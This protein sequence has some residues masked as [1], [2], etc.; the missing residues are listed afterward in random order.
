MKLKYLTW[1]SPQEVDRGEIGH[2]EGRYA[3]VGDDKMGAGG[4][5]W[6]P[7]LMETA[8]NNITISCFALCSRLLIS[9]IKNEKIAKYGKN[10]L[11]LKS[12]TY[13]L[14]MYRLIFKHLS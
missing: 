12:L 4:Y 9:F 1:C 10:S 13:W 2:E 8:M 7:L 5:D 6:D 14:P 11:T 3:K